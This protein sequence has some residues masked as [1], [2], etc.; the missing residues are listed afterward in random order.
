MWEKTVLMETDETQANPVK[1]RA[2]QASR[3]K[4][5]PRRNQRSERREFQVGS[6]E[7]AG[8]ALS[9]RQN[10]ELRLWDQTKVGRGKISTR[11]SRKLGSSTGMPSGTMSF[12]PAL[13]LCTPVVSF[14]IKGFGLTFSTLG[15]REQIPLLV[16][17]A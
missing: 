5:G 15:S 4:C 17:P 14:T 2:K 11:N 10:Q 7:R 16:I 12:G 9:I 8:S 6:T 3:K 1:N 13:A